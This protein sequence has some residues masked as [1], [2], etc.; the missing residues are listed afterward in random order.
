[1]AKLFRL[2]SHFSRPG[3]D[4]ERGTGFGLL[5]CQ[6]LLTKNGLGLEATSQEGAGSTFAFTLPT[7]REAGGD[8]RSCSDVP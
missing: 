6:E 5:F 8:S 2:D 7:A 1:L 4:G 3:T